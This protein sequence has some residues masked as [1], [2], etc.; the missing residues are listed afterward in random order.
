M[1]G[2]RSVFDINAAAAAD[3]KKTR[4]SAWS[5]LSEEARR[6]LVAK[7]VGSN[8]TLPD[9]ATREAGAFAAAAGWDASVGIRGQTAEV[10]LTGTYAT[11]FL[12]LIGVTN[13]D[14][15]GTASATA[16]PSG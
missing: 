1:E 3:L 15:E 11:T 14:V 6:S 10:T 4:A 8:E 5:G 12:G 7:V 9:P 2:E 13:I 16:V